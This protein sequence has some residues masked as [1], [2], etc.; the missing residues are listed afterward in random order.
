MSP[1]TQ[2]S[3]PSSSPTMD[4]PRARI[5]CSRYRLQFGASGS[6]SARVVCVLWPEIAQTGLIRDS[7]RTTM[8]G[9][10][11]LVPMPHHIN[12]EVLIAGAGPV[13]LSLAMDLAQRGV[14]V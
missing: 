4:D 5:R 1:S 9:R 8:N 12:T 3:D 11:Q 13:G 7:P 6:E 2:V 14:G 10:W